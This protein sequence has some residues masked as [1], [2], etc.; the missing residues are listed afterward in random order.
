[1]NNMH[2]CT[3]EN[4]I[5]KYKQLIGYWSCLFFCLIKDCNSEKK[6]NRSQIWL[7]NWFDWIS[8]NKYCQ[9]KLFACIL[10]ELFT[11]NHILNGWNM[12]KD[13]RYRFTMKNYEYFASRTVRKQKQF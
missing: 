4:N 7:I 3:N 2:D 10:S 9:K 8:I 6:F 1:M 13:E 11:D 12:E 5:I